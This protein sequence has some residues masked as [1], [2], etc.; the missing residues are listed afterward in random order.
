LGWDEVGVALRLYLRAGAAADPMSEPTDLSVVR[1][2][3]AEQEV[4]LYCGA[5]PHRTPLA[6][7][8]IKELMVS[9]EG[10]ICGITFVDDFFNEETPDDAA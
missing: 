10:Y 1:G 5:K 2:K 6:C 8:R 7:P 3:K 9:E 4:C